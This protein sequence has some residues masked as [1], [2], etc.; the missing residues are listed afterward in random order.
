MIRFKL[1]GFPITVHWMFWVVLGILGSNLAQG[2]DGILKLA[3]WVVAG[4]ISVLIHELGHT[5]LQRKFG[6]RPQIILYAMGGLAVP[7]RGFTRT[8][9]IIISLGGPLLQIAVGLAARELLRHSSGDSMPVV[10]FLFSFQWI[11]IAW[12]LLNLLPIYPLD[13]GQVL[14]GILGPQR[15]K[16]AYLVGMVLAVGLGI[17]VL[18][19]PHPSVWN[20]M[21]CGLLAWDNFQRWQGQ[22]PPASLNPR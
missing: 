14:R 16:Q 1:L 13:G 3:L 5:F 19:R 21:M 7:D 17:Y 18:T 8:Q 20:A 11:S 10:V 9:H 22:T 15:E 12:G 2:R 6:A 4:F